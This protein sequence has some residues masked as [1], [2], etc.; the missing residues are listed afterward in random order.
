MVAFW[1]RLDFYFFNSMFTDTAS[2]FTHF[3][4]KT[5]LVVILWLAWYW[6]HWRDGIG[7]LYSVF[8]SYLDSIRSWSSSKSNFWFFWPPYIV[9]YGSVNSLKCTV[10]PRSF[11]LKIRSFWCSTLVHSRSSEQLSNFVRILM[12]Q[13]ILLISKSIV[14]SFSIFS[15]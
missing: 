5:I 13:N 14:S 2:L 7:K 11:Q 15:D 6:N 12:I 10:W 9:N 1:S 8:F 4:C 3:L